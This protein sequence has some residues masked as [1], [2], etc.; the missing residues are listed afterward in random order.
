MTNKQ[1]FDWEWDTIAGITAAVVAIVLHL[2]HIVDEHVILP[3]VLALLGLL[4]V[5]FMR[6]RKSIELT[7]ERV[8]NMAHAVNRV[9][10][11]IKSPDILLIGPR[12]IRNANEQFIRH[13]S[14]DTIWYNVCLSMYKRQPLFDTLLRP[15]I[16]NPKVSSIQ[17]VLDQSQVDLWEEHVKPKILKCVG[18]E[19]IKDPRWCNLSKTISFILADSQLSEGAEALLSFWGEPF[20]AQTTAHDVPRFIFQVQKHSELLPHLVELS[21]S[22]VR[23]QQST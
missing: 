6:H 19:K 9:R 11:S 14:G 21:H 3:I 1:L 7:A 16:E 10:A 18:H 2:L 15:A 22:Y 8:D 23:M 20:M 5:N 4:F 17:F 12:N 13:M